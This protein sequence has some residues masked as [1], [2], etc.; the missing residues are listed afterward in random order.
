MTCG[1]IVL[2]IIELVVVHLGA[3]G[4][5]HKA[6]GVAISEE[7]A[8]FIRDTNRVRVVEGRG[9]RRREITEG[10]K[11]F[12]VLRIEDA[13]GGVL[14]DLEE[15]LEEGFFREEEEPETGWL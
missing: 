2:D 9:R 7:E 13:E 10:E 4:H 3:N 11:V 12:G 1:Q 6:L 15:D 8:V 5:G 14:L